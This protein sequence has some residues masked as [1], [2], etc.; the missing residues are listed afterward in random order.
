MGGVQDNAGVWWDH[1]GG[2]MGWRLGVGIGIRRYH[3]PG[4]WVDRDRLKV[5]A[6]AAGQGW[7]ALVSAANAE[8]HEWLT[9]LALVYRGRMVDALVG[10]RVE[11][12]W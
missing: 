8:E 1:D 6:L 4:P 2:R 10:F 11:M 7:P 9:S 3:N 5:L 12:G